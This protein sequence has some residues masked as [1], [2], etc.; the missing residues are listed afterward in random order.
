M[1]IDVDDGFGKGVRRF[2]RQI[3]A[4]AAFD[5]AVRILAGEFLGIGAGVATFVR[6]GE[7]TGPARAERQ[8]NVGRL[9]HRRRLLVVEV[10]TR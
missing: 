9:Q 7:A 8:G 10:Q 3:V 4:D 1:A 6:N 5:G 2:L